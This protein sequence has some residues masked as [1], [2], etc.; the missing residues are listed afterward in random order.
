[1]RLVWLA[2][3]RDWVGAVAYA[4]TAILLPCWEQDAAYAATPIGRA[5]LEWNALAEEVLLGRVDDGLRNRL[6]AAAARVTTAADAACAAGE[7]LGLPAAITSERDQLM[8]WALARAAAPEGRS[9]G[10][11]VVAVV[12][13][14]H[15][16]GVGQWLQEYRRRAA[17]SPSGERDER[18]PEEIESLLQV[19]REYAVTNLGGPLVA[20]SGLLWA[21]V[22]GLRRY[23]R[24]TAAAL[25]VTGLATAVVISGASALQSQWKRVLEQPQL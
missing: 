22:R 15:T 16:R 20:A 6:C 13:S 25:S 4:R 8:G 2:A 9:R 14:A 12:G 1:M 10:G 3:W 19:P 21:A 5:A 17:R 23:P 24:T 18:I 7:D 11:A